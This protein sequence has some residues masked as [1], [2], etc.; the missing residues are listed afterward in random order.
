M[1]KDIDSELATNVKAAKTKRMYFA[2]VAKGSSDGALVLAKTKVP[3]ALITDAKKRSGGTQVVKGACFGEDGKL[4]FEMAKEPPATMEAALKKVIQRDSG[5]TQV[6]VCRRGTA[7]DL[8]DDDA[9]TG[10]PTTAAPKVEAVQRSDSPPASSA[11]NL[12]SQYTAYYSSL[13][14]QLIKALKDKTPDVEKLKLA[15]SYSRDQAASKQYAK[16]IQGLGVLKTLLDTHYTA[17]ASTLSA[18]TPASGN[19]VGGQ[20]APAVGPATSAAAAEALAQAKL[21]P[22]RIDSEWGRSI[23]LSKC[24]VKFKADAPHGEF[25]KLGF[26]ESTDPAAPPLVIKVPLKEQGADDLQKEVDF[27]KQVGEHPNF[28][29]CLGIADVGGQ[30]GMVMEAVKG[31]DMGKTMD[32]LKDQYASGKISHEEYWGAVQHTV[33]QTLEAIAH[34]ESVGVVHNDIRMD[35]IMCDEATGQMKVLDFGVSVQAGQA[36]E[37]T[38]I[39]HGTVSPDVIVRDERG[40]PRSSRGAVT[41]KHDVF[42]VGAAG[43]AA[44]EKQVFDYGANTGLGTF[45]ALIKFGDVDAAGKSQQAIKPADK[46]NPA[47]VKDAQGNARHVAGRSGADT[48]YTKFIN[49][50][51]DPD[52]KKRLSPADALKE[53]FLTDSLM[54]EEQARGVFKKLLT[55][56]APAA[57][58]GSTPAATPA[59]STPPSPGPG[60]AES[61]QAYSA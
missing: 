19:S 54:D 4:V 33:R 29:K 34:L 52:P 42:S 61:P 30:R 32:K 46:D 44:G 36:T 8:A 37:K 9:A 47:F 23:D 43:F 11:T 38:P 40:T 60:A 57:P 27:Y 41:S 56:E 10:K 25:G 6:C 3:P 55:P 21:K 53:P 13:E 14:P 49:R 16:A 2:F 7:P 50:L 39:G 5:L 51:M 26:I 22:E 15:F 59:R 24:N 48:T 1:A 20:S 58:T 18:T 12:P 45:Q 28:P 17:Y 31:K 35:N